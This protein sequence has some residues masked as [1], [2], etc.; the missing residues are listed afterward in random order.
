MLPE[1]SVD[2]AGLATVVPLGGLALEDVNECVHKEKGRVS[3][4]LN[5]WLPGLL[6]QSVLLWTG[7]KLKMVRTTKWHTKIVTQCNLKPSESWI[8][9]S[10]P[11]WDQ[12]KG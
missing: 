5:C 3:P 4:A 12:G 8:G 6:S 7:M 1:P 9:A 10:L 2:I 11:L